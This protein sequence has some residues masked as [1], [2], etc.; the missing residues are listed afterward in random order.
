MIIWTVLDSCNIILDRT[1]A[2]G[3]AGTEIPN[4]CHIV[5]RPGARCTTCS[6]S[7]I[8]TARGKAE[9]DAVVVPVSP[10]SVII[11]RPATLLSEEDSLHVP[12]S[13]KGVAS[14]T[15]IVFGAHGQGVLWLAK[16]IDHVRGE[17]LIGAKSP[18][19]VVMMLLVYSYDGA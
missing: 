13:S 3:L 17:I 5:L 14:C 11:G 10:Q 15:V 6:D 4:F 19:P 1:G 9:L 8:I 7:P 16:A 12:S 2:P 18:V